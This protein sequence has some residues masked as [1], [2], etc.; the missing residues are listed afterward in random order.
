MKI[1]IRKQKEKKY[2]LRE[3]IEH[4]KKVWEIQ[5]NSSYSYPIIPIKII[6]I[7]KS[8]S[9]ENRRKAFSNKEIKETSLNGRACLSRLTKSPT[10]CPIKNKASS[11]SSTSSSSSSPS[12][13]VNKY[14][15]LF[16]TLD[17]KQSRTIVLERR[18]TQHEPAPSPPDFLSGTLFLSFCREV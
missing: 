8:K 16:T 2:S 13:K 15:W 3:T 12:M 4:F 6:G 10:E 14:M 9:R 11:S 17:N 18:E 1:E 5:N 7:P